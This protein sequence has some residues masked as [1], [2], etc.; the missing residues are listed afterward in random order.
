MSR[1]VVKNGELEKALYKYKKMRERDGIQGEIMKR[2]AY[3][4]PSK[5]HK[6]K[7]YLAIRRMKKMRAKHSKNYDEP[8]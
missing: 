4:K 3:T 2:K 8:L 5:K 7:H 6:D 1:I